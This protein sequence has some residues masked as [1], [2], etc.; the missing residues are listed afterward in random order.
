[1]SSAA[2]TILAVLGL[3]LSSP[4]AA[5]N[6]VGA[7][8]S[9]SQIRRRLPLGLADR[10]DADL[11][12]ELARQTLPTQIRLLIP[13][14]LAAAEPT[15]AQVLAAKGDPA[16][17]VTLL[18]VRLT[19]PAHKLPKAQT[20]F[21]RVTTALLTRHLAD[22]DTAATLRPA[23]DAAITATLA[24]IDT[25][26]ALL[27][28]RAEGLDL[29]EGLLLPLARRHAP[30]DPADLPAALANLQAALQAATRMAAPQPDPILAAI[31]A[32]VMRQN[33]Q[34]QLAEAAATLTEAQQLLGSQATPLA[35]PRALHQLTLDQARLLAAPDRAAQAILTDIAT[36]SPPTGQFRAIH[37]AWERW[38][39]QG[40]TRAL[41]FDLAT[42][43][44]LARANLD[45][46]KGVQRAQALGDLAIT[47]FRLGEVQAGTQGL[48]DAIATFRIFLAEHP[49][50]TDPAAWAT[51]KVN[52]AVALT[53]LATRDP[54]PAHLD[55]AIA[56]FRAALQVQTEA[57]ADFAATS[58]LLAAAEQQRAGQPG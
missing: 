32:E 28:T 40:D 9:M 10:L 21:A 34:G 52:M 26:A 18:L 37:A 11:A 33:A 27:A 5:A 2:H 22:P 20:G 46:S 50:K 51:V 4:Q 29:P 23:F 48:T 45:R 31:Q 6:G 3:A 19:D 42:A 35:D 30:A 47:Q 36:Q 55:E 58:A 13:Q 7:A 54:N 41:T 44:Y 38:F 12:Q 57:T 8:F 25:N 16:R 14:M 39:D 49:R 56:A 24:D 15:P 1:M 43:L 17:L 53:T